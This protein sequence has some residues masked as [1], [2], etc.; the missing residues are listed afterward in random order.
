M[1]L[2]VRIIRNCTVGENLYKSVE[3]PPVRTRVD[4]RTGNRLYHPAFPLIP[5]GFHLPGVG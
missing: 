2:P 4:N 3:K 1:L 5:H